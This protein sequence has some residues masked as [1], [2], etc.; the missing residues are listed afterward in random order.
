[1]RFQLNLT[2]RCWCLAALFHFVSNS[3]GRSETFAESFANQISTSVRDLTAERDALKSELAETPEPVL[4][5]P[6]ARLGFHSHTFFEQESPDAIVL[7]LGESYR[8][9][10][11]SLVPVKIDNPLYAA[12]DYG[13][14]LRF[15]VEASQ[16]ADFSESRILIDQRE[17]DFPA[18]LGLPVTFETEQTD[19]RYIRITSTKHPPNLEHF[20][21]ALGEIC[22]ISGNRNVTT[23]AVVKFN[24]GSQI[25]PIWAPE[26]L[27]DAHHI[28]AIPLSRKTSPSNGWLAEH[29][30]DPDRSKWV[31]VDLE[32]AYDIDEIRL[33]PARPTDMAD[34]PGMGFPPKYRVEAWSSETGQWIK[35]RESGKETEISQGDNPVVILARG[36][37]ASRV[38]VTAEKLWQ[39]ND[40]ANFALAEMQ[41]FADEINIALGKPVTASDSFSDPRFPRWAPTFLVDGYSSQF[42]LIDWPRYLLSIN[43][44]R[45]LTRK[46][47][48][49]E[50]LRSEKVAKVMK[51]LVFAGGGI[52]ALLILIPSVL[53]TR[54]LNQRKRE[55]KRL[56]EQIARDLHD[57]IGSNL[58]GI[59]LL[60][61][62]DELREDL[63]KEVREDLAE[64]HSIATSSSESM[65]DIIW[66]IQKEETNARQLILRLRETA[67]QICG[68]ME[69]DFQTFPDPVPNLPVSLSARR[70]I[71]L[72]FKETLHNVRK[73][74]GASKIS[75][76]FQVEPRKRT[77]SFEVKDNGK[78][79]IHS[80]N[81]TGNG[82]SNLAQRAERCDGECQVESS[83]DRGTV[84]HFKAIVS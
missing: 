24:R 23:D 1:M 72:A 16:S 37:T 34:T 15:Y 9:D 17:S 60:S 69:I 40:R 19:A 76:S 45:D 74:A 44:Y 47:K 59:A 20:V 18:P 38:R 33:I 3:E 46:L 50:A 49:V 8:V 13:F 2:T 32:G 56:R 62:V 65:R 21:W 39:R 25:P 26:N 80:A 5:Q 77:I 73:H 42:Q 48:E 84:I 81:L 22:V 35:L 54:S 43:S 75:I 55:T 57:D 29:G 27:V 52:L 7:D 31:E 78:G 58:G 68:K 10:L 71:F 70:H 36:I 79:F 82:L 11:V 53:L 14:P 51:Y 28:A 66:L 4:V 67:L 6:S 63:P 64:I 12:S 83:P 61:E 41:I 30:T